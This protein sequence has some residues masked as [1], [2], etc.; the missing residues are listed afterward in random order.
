MPG[1]AHLAEEPK[2][3]LIKGFGSFSLAGVIHPRPPESGRF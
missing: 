2:V 1:S 3:L